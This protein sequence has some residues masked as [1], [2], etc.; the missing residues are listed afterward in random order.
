MPKVELQG[1]S[2]FILKDVSLTIEDGEFMVLLGRNGAGKSTLL[3]AVSGL[4]PY[5]GSVLFDGRRVDG[6]PTEK[7]NVGYLFQ[8]LALFPHMHVAANIAYGMKMKHRCSK[9][10][11]TARVDELMRMVKIKHLSGRFPRD[12]SGGEKQRVAFARALACSPSILLMD[13][14]LGSLDLGSAKY[15]RMEFVQ[16]QRRVGA[17]TLFVTHNL[18]EAA[19]IADRIA[20]FENGELLQVGTPEEILFDPADERVRD[21]VGRPNIFECESSHIIENGLAIAKCGGMTIVTPHEGEPVKKIAIAPEHVYVSTEKPVGPSVN[22]FVG[23]VMAKTSFPAW[24]RLT[25]QVADRQVLAEIPKEMSD[26]MAIEV[27]SKVHVILK[28][29][30]VK[31]LTTETSSLKEKGVKHPGPRNPS[32]GD[33]RN[34]LPSYSG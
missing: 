17:T 29:R 31:V 14:P 5:Q 21:F 19:E 20:I 34:G 3:N 2:N 7:R 15:M 26:M 12:L 25:I 33:L 10:E 24:V 23:C 27:G 1:L 30:W 4:I 8:H 22:R 16:L 32:Q 18:T 13:E 11:M 28:L 9:P 6:F